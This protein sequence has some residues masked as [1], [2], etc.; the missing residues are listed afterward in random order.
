M[1][2]AV[3]GMGGGSYSGTLAFTD[4]QIISSASGTVDILSDLY[5]AGSIVADDDISGSGDLD[6]TGK[7]TFGGTVSAGGL[8]T[9]SGGVIIPSAN[10]Y[11]FSGAGKDLV[12]SCEMNSYVSSAGGWEINSST[13][14]WTTNSTGGNRCF[15]PLHL[16]HG[17]TLVSA[18]FSY[19][20]AP[21]APGGGSSPSATLM[22][23]S[24]DDGSMTVL[25]FLATDTLYASFPATLYRQP[26]PLTLTPPANTIV[27]RTLYRYFMWVTSESGAGATIGA[28]ILGSFV[29]IT[30]PLL[31]GE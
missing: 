29:H 15:Q 25:A 6:M 16:P 1:V 10:N 18:S 27:N 9:G 14:L 13:N 19:K 8:I 24:I 11:S 12:L 4:L 26:H 22:R 5:V 3:D 2:N 21:T 30:L 23:Q 28:S 17:C 31:T 7:G 20:G